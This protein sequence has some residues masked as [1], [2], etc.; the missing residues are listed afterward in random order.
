[1]IKLFEKEQYHVFALVKCTEKQS[2]A[3]DVIKTNYCR[4][5]DFT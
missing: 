5:I 3:H 2:L 4:Q 1:M